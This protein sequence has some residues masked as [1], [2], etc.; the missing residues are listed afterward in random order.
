MTVRTTSLEALTTFRNDPGA[1]DLVISDQTMP[2]MTGFDLARRMLQ[3][4]PQLPIILCTG[5]STAISEEK[6]K[7]AGIKRFVMK[8]LAKKDLASLI[9]K[10]LDGEK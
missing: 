8:S 2:G 3:I 10:V 1:F 6:N 4:K 5:Y 7:S 9:R